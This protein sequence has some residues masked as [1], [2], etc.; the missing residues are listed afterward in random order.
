MLINIYSLYKDYE[1]AY[2]IAA[3]LV[4]AEGEF[5]FFLISQS[6]HDQESIVPWSAS[7]AILEKLKW[8]ERMSSVGTFFVSSRLTNPFGNGFFCDWLC[9]CAS[10]LRQF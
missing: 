7:R 2:R 1:K 5:M 3:R 9:A 4:I 8:W 6:S 10:D